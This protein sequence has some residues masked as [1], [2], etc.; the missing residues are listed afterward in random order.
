MNP[1][2]PS[3]EPSSPPGIGG[4]VLLRP[5]AAADAPAILALS[6][7]DGMRTWLPDQVYADLGAARRVVGQ[8]LA[9]LREP[10]TPLRAP[11]VLAV[12]RDDAPAPIGHVGLSPLADEV[13]VGYAVGERWQRQGFASAAV[14]RMVEWGL[15][16]FALPRVLGIVAD[17]NAASWRVLERVGF[18]LVSR[19]PG[20]LH[21]RA[22]LM[23]TYRFGPAAD[24]P[25][26][27][28]RRERR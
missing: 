23:R 4:G 27:D 6:Q 20:T 11:F 10:G 28:A 24:A 25:V 22:G 12:C 26:G 16:R 5:F 2:S 3:F 8:L 9:W 19:I 7:E 21:G 13:E 18:A 17:D 1:P 14:R 15:P